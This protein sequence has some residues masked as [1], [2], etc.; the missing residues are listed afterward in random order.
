MPDCDCMLKTIEATGED[1]EGA[2]VAAHRGT[3][4]ESAWRRRQ[5]EGGARGR[6]SWEGE[7]DR[8]GVGQGRR[9][10][11]EAEK[12]LMEGLRE[13]GRLRRP[14]SQALSG[15]GRGRSGEARN[16]QQQL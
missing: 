1:S 6:R 16:L 8:Q 11:G 15:S 3:C 14:N 7:A 2:I 12:R 10:N 5:V 4:P 13:S 9:R